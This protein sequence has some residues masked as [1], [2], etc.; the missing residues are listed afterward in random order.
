MCGEHVYNDETIGDATLVNGG[1]IVDNDDLEDTTQTVSKSVQDD[2]FVASRLERDNMYSQ[3]LDS[4]QKMIDS[5]S[6]TNEQKAIAQKEIKKINDNKNAIMIIENI[7]KTKGIEDIV[8]FINGESVNAVVK[9]EK[10]DT[11]RNSS[12]SEHYFKRT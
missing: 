3:V 6:I 9:S 8:I 12:N 7:V 4:Y 1:A 5:T 2:Y 10:L 11:R